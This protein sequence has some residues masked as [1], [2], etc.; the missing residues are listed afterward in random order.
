MSSDNWVVYW[1]A[2]PIKY[3]KVIEIIWDNSIPW[4]LMCLPLW[5]SKVNSSNTKQQCFFVQKSFSG[6]GSPDLPQISPPIDILLLSIE[7]DDFFHLFSPQIHGCV[8]N[9]WRPMN[10]TQVS[11]G[12]IWPGVSV[13]KTMG[14]FFWLFPGPGPLRRWTHWSRR[15]YGRWEMDEF[16]G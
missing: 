15:P 9:W 8:W 7:S 13:I 5:R 16:K 2:I 14:F 11:W 10:M 1:I 4:I 12:K 3:N 6:K